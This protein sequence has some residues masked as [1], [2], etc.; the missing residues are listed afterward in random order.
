MDG[1]DRNRDSLP[2]RQPL[3]WRKLRHIAGAWLGALFVI[4]I[5]FYIVRLAL[6][7]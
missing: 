5:V 1:Q 7:L 3:R 4:G 2:P 6:R